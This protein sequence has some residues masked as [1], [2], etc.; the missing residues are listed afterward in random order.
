MVIVL[1]TKK[2]S[3][4]GVYLQN[5]K[6]PSKIGNLVNL[7]IGN[8]EIRKFGNSGKKWNRGHGSKAIHICRQID[9]FVLFIPMLPIDIGGHQYWLVFLVAAL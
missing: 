5:T 2:E 9:K 7:E 4:P 8:L 3:L 1:V 6:Y